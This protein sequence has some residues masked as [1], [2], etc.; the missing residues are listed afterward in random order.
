M[1]GIIFGLLVIPV[2]YISRHFFLGT[3]VQTLNSQNHTATLRRLFGIVDYNLVIEVDG[4]KVYHSGDIQGIS[5]KQLR[6]TLV[7][8]ETG[9]V[10]VFEKMGEIVFAYDA[11]EKRKMNVE[12][13]KNYCLSPMPDSYQTQVN[14]SCEKNQ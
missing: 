8:D 6:A 12:E 4:Q 7:W 3:P 13:L 11:Y 9:R 2:G 1:F 10:V 14:N 5:E